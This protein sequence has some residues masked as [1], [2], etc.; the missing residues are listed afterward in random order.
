MR[1]FIHDRFCLILVLL[2]LLIPQVVNGQ[3]ETS[4]ELL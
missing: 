1:T 2:Y 4:Q 3:K